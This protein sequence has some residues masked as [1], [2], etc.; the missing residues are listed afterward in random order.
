MDPSVSVGQS[1]EVLPKNGRD[2]TKKENR[3]LPG[4]SPWKKIIVALAGPLGNILLA[5]LVAWIVYLAGKPSLPAER[6]AVIGYVE[7]NS[8]AYAGGLRT[9][10]EIMAVN[11]RTVKNWEE[12]IQENTRFEKVEL[13]LKT[14]R[15]IITISLPTEKNPLGFR[16]VP[17]IYAVTS[18]KIM[19]VEPDSSAAAAGLQSGDLVKKIDDMEV[20]SADHLIAI[21]SERADQT[22]TVMVERSG[23]P[24]TMNVTPRFDSSLGRARIGIR[25]DQLA[26]DYDQVVHITPGTQMKGH[27]LLIFRVLR[28]L[29]TP[30]EAKATSQALGGPLMIIYTLQAVVRKGVIIALWFTCLLNVNLAI[31][32]LIPLPVLDGGHVVFALLEIVTRRPVPPKIALF[33]NQV[34]FVLLIMLLIL[35]TGQDLKRFYGIFQIRFMSKPPAEQQTVTNN[36]APPVSP[37]NQNE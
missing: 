24:L 36:I 20:L 11:G 28:S 8:A 15:G 5:Y 31:L 37:T 33:L 34:F 19:A 3:S 18:C 22:V 35:I 23:S 27:A 7:T 12:V 16:I 30:K 9:G 10:D 2:E 6:S 14:S 4:V 32:N 21:I 25:F 17:G 13:L 1:S 26:L 29:M